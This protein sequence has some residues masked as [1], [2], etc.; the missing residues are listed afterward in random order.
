MNRAVEESQLQKAERPR[1]VHLHAETERI[2]R[3]S[4][5]AA[6]RAKNHWTQALQHVRAILHSPAHYRG[7]LSVAG[8]EHMDGADCFDGA[9]VRAGE[10]QQEGTDEV[11]DEDLPIVTPVA[12]GRLKDVARVQL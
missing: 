11:D 7:P 3:H 8:N 9:R 12:D 1:L 5:A 4:R 2:L 6:A 10:R